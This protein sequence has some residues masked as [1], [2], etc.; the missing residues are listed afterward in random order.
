MYLYCHICLYSTLE[1]ATAIKSSA[2]EIDLGIRRH[3]LTYN[4]IAISIHRNM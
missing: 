4:I 3:H 1:P 2:A